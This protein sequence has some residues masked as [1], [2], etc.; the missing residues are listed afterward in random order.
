MSLRSSAVGNPD[1][2]T[3]QW[4]QVL[5]A[6]TE[7]PAAR[8]ALS[9]LC[10]AYYA[11]VH[12]YIHRTT[13]DL[14]EARDLTH[15]F[16]ERLLAGS[17]LGGVQPDRGRFRNYLLGAVKH[18]LADVRDKQNAH[19][20]GN[21]HAH[22]PLAAGSNFGS[23]EGAVDPVDPR[24]LPPDAWF[25]RQWALTVLNRALDTLAEEH[26]VAGRIAHFAALK[27]WLAGDRPDLSQAEA[28]AGLKISEG[29]FKVS[30]HRLRHRFRDQVKREIAATLAHP[31]D[32]EDELQSLLRAL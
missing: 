22:L 7:S 28:A 3:T 29:A 17:M 15:A 8:A 5:A 11:P 27:P 12:A 19:K 24:V 21:S 25:D 9:D 31:G 20:R 13:R 30:L 6:R 4:T 32:A 10:A 1:F 2:S 14:G 16:F 18:F 26:G 23:T